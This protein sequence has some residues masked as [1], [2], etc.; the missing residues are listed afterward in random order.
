LIYK[1]FK[2]KISD[3][4]RLKRK[5]CYPSSFFIC[6]SIRVLNVFWFHFFSSL[7][8]NVNRV[9]CLFL[10]SPLPLWRRD[11]TNTK[12]L[13]E[14]FLLFKCF[15]SSEITKIMGR[16]R[17][18]KE[19]TKWLLVIEVSRRHKGNCELHACPSKT[20]IILM[21]SFL[22]QGSV[23]N[24]SNFKTRTQSFAGYVTG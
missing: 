11:T 16:I 19:T 7:E 24:E 15:K 3:E 10:H 17:T 2:N 1:I 20:N 9:I 22:L 12:I 18:T 8:N 14:I 4:H 21:F 23:F 6:L 13:F 5:D